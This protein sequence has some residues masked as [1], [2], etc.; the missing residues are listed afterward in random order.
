MNSMEASKSSDFG[1]YPNRS[2]IALWCNGN[3]PDSDSGIAGSSP[4]RA[5]LG[6]SYNGYYS[7]LLICQIRVRIPDGPLIWLHSLAGQDAGLSSLKYGFK[8]RR[9]YYIAP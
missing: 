6:H 3:T 5:A 1:L 7:R 2:A 4:V 8:S 9:S